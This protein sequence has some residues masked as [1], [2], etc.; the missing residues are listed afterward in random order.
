MNM[1]GFN[2]D[3][4]IRTKRHANAAKTEWDKVIEG[5]GD[6]LFYGFG[7]CDDGQP[8]IRH[9]RIGDLNILRREFDNRPTVFQNIQHNTDGRTSF[10]CIRW[11]DMPQ[12]FIVTSSKEWPTPHEVAKSQRAAFIASWNRHAVKPRPLDLQMRLF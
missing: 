1:F 12:E 3:F 2:G 11:G 10:R 4:T 9:Y 6:W 8:I 7:E 5:W